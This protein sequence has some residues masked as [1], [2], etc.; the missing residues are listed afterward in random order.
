[1]IAYKVYV[2]A[3]YQVIY[4]PL[5]NVSKSAYLTEC[6]S[7]P[8]CQEKLGQKEQQ[9]EPKLAGHR[10]CCSVY[11]RT[12]DN[13]I[14]LPAREFGF[15]REDIHLLLSAHPKSIIFR[16]YVDQATQV[17]FRAVGF[18]TF[19]Q[20]WIDLCPYIV[21]TKPMSDQCWQCQQNNSHI[22]QSANLTEEEKIHL[23]LEQQQQHLGQVKSEGKLYQAMTTDA[24]KQ[25]PSRK[26]FNDYKESQPIPGT[27]QCTTVL[28]LL[29]RCTFI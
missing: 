14:S 10:N 28:T 19:L 5:N 11:K 4:C 15:K 1:M 22:Y 29:N 9:Q 17:E 6:G 13:A 23:V 3:W 16:L 25:L 27:L 18:S 24:K 26:N 12:E 20:L 2:T 8:T 7:F 21:V